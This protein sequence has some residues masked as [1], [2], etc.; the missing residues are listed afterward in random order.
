MTQKALAE[1]LHVTDKAVSRGGGRG[2]G[3]PDPHARAARRGARGQPSRAAPCR[4]GNGGR[5]PGPTARRQM[6]SAFSRRRTAAACTARITKRPC[7]GRSD[8]RGDLHAG[9]RVHTQPDAHARAALVYRR[10]RRRARKAACD[11]LRCAPAPEQK[12]TREQAAQGFAAAP[13]QGII[14]E[15]LP[16][17]RAKPVGGDRIEGVAALK[18]CEVFPRTRWGN[19]NSS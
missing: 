7:C 17:D 3:Y 5:T 16:A 1:R 12:R 14:K 6:R 8:H 9:L 4:A 10:R 2:L 13:A 15:A 19:T 11:F 18:T